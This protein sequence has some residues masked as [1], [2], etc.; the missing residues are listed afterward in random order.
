MELQLMGFSLTSASSVSEIINGY[1][2][3]GDSNHSD[4]FPYV[5][6]AVNSARPG[7]HLWEILKGIITNIVN[8][9]AN[10]LDK[11]HGRAIVRYLRDV[12]RGVIVDGRTYFHRL[13]QYPGF[14][15]SI[16]R[17]SGSAT[18]LGAPN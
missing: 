10:Q 1:D 17:P 11:R 2:S 18:D 4:D 16:S 6:A 3:D 12:G 7:A 8:G 14:R 9:T 15:L 5:Q 13:F